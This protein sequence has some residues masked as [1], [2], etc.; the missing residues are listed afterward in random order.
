MMARIQVGLI[1]AALCCVGCASHPRLPAVEWHD[2][3]EAL[4]VLSRRGESIRTL[5]AQGDITLQR[6]NGESVRLDLAMVRAGHDRVRI[7]AWKLG[8]AVF[9]LTMNP[10]GVWLLTPQDGSLRNKARSAGLTARKLAENLALLGGDLFREPNLTVR[11]TG[12]ELDI[13]SSPRSDGTRVRC[14]VDRRTLV[15][16]R[17]LLLDREDAARFTLDLSKYRMAGD[18]PLAYRYLATS[19]EGRIIIVLREI[20]LNSDLAENAFV[21]PRRAEQLP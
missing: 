20:E 21:P 7:R 4:S 14:L 16:V 11:D 12:R 9:D 15:P 13:D 19:D 18:V 10:K 5:T 2:S 17:Y 8:T 3:R 6:P 1:L